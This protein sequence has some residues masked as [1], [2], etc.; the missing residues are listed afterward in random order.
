MKIPKQMS[1]SDWHDLQSL[2]QDIQQRRCTI[3][4]G[5]VTAW[6]IGRRQ[7]TGSASQPTILAQGTPTTPWKT[8]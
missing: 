2:Q 5:L 3:L 7:F 6:Q 8:S 4:D 1:P